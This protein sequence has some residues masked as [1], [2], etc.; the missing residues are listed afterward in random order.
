M[1]VATQSN[2]VE[3]DDDPTTTHPL[4][5]VRSDRVDVPIPLETTIPGVV[6][7]GIIC[8]ILKTCAYPILGIVKRTARSVRMYFFMFNNY[9]TL[10]MLP[11]RLR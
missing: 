6:D 5:P 4:E 8:E 3:T 1:E 9:N 10:G 7:A 11:K 2:F